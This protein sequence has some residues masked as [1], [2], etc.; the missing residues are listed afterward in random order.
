MDT[1]VKVPQFQLKF[2][3]GEIAAC[4]L[5]KRR[6]SQD[7]LKTLHMEKCLQCI[8]A[9]WHGTVT[10]EPN[11]VHE[12]AA[13]K[14]FWKRK[15]CGVTILTVVYAYGGE[16]WHHS[17]KRERGPKGGLDGTLILHKRKRLG[18]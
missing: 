4:Y 13:V 18:G 8:L 7:G 3:P 2:L 17:F 14:D 11:E 10:H 15:Y 1:P 5:G 6:F 12:Y 9:C 16:T